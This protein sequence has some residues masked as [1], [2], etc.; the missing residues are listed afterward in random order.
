MEIKP[1]RV[2]VSK[3]L[4]FLRMITKKYGAEKSAEVWA[5]VSKMIDDDELTMGVMT[6]MLKGGFDTNDFIVKHWHDD[7][8]T[9][10]Q[11]TGMKVQAIKML[12]TWTLCGLKESKDAIDNAS[13]HQSTSFKIHRKVDEHGELA[14]IEYG[15]FLRD[16]A[17]VG[18][19]VELD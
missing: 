14:D 2:R 6:I 12:R 4:A 7:G 11:G 18:I 1:S 8:T 16:M 3:T 9:N 10:G 17:S 15:L 19:T 5:V 13:N